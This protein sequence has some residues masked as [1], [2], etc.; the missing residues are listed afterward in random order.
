LLSSKEVLVI[1]PT[2]N[3]VDTIASQI[4]SI[5]QIYQGIKILVI[6]DG[7]TD[8]TIQSLNSLSNLKNNLILIQRGQRLGLGSAYRDGFKLAYKNGFHYVIQMDG[9]GSH[10]VKDLEQLLKAPGEID[11]VIG[12]RYVRGGKIA[13]WKLSRRFISRAGN[14][15]TKRMLCLKVN[16]ATSG[17]KRLSRKVFSDSKLLNSNTNGYGFQIEIINF[18]KLHNFSALE[19]PITFI[20][21]RFGY[22][23]F[24]KFI[25][26]EALISVLKWTIKR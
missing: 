25:V 2:L 12:S 17:F 3:E 16:D 18:C 10:L 8:G 20:D 1:I 24:N 21:R 23:K 4:E 11:L 6:D 7:S 22:S 5:I 14:I 13:G 19:V 15:F 9:D 26:L